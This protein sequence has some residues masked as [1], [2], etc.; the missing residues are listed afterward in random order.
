MARILVISH[1][2]TH[3]A[4][5][6]NRARVYSLL[7]AL[8]GAGH[9]VCL[10]LLDDG[11]DND[12]EAMA[13]TWD[14]FW[15]FPYRFPAPGLRRGMRGLVSRLLKV[16]RYL[17]YGVDDWYNG[18]LDQRL[19]Q[20]GGAVAFDVVMVEYVFFSKALV[21]FPGA[22]KI[23]DTHDI[24]GDR[25]RLFLRHGQ[26]PS[27]F[28]TTAAEEGKGLNRAD[29][30]LAIQEREKAFFSSLAA[31]K[32]V[33]TV[34]HT[35]RI[36]P[37][38]PG[39]PFSNRLLFIGSDNDVNRHAL[40]YF[41]DEVWPAIR[42]RSPATQLEVVGTICRRYRRLPEG[43]RA[44]GPVDDL[45]ACY[46]QADVV[47]NPVRFGTGLKIKNVEALGYGMP[48]VTTGV[49]AEGI[50]EGSGRAFWVADSRED[51][52]EKT[53]RLL[54]DEP[55]R[56]RLAE[57]ALTF[58]RSYNDRATRPLLEFIDRELEKKRSRP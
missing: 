44:T 14:R 37:P 52:F 5:S 9:E 13:R 28:Y 56:Q 43:C 53:C 54:E 58:A 11:G 10:F 40:A 1:A 17:P 41:L 26:R 19:R 32:R 42:T 18:G 2:P 21:C 34:G 25:H 3:P 4:N 33:M 24:F 46:A 15:A 31:D 50:E 48:L 39:K 23:L 7:N 12:K 20:L 8:Q 38:A 57:A 49:G 47:I 51:F 35:T 16:D 6:G 36:A 22:L 29:V 55:A 27:W 30:I 45:G